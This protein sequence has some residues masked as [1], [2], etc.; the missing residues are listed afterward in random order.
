MIQQ[1]HFWDYSQRKGKQDIKKISETSL[2]V[3]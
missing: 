3:H 1:S 2:G